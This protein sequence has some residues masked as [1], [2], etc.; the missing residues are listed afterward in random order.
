MHP[1]DE[2]GLLTRLDPHGMMA[3][4]LDFP[5]QCERAM[6]LASDA[7]APALPRPAQCN[8]PQRRLRLPQRT[9]Q[10]QWITSTTSITMTTI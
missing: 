4:T 1:L 8:D 3:L 2:S 9:S 7:P 6:L 5:A 10:R